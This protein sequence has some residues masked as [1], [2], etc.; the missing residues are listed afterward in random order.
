[1][2]ILSAAA[3]SSTVT[4]STLEGRPFLNGRRRH[5]SLDICLSRLYR[6]IKMSAGL[7]ANDI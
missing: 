6:L 1:M 5:R 4:V 2:A 7:R 3:N